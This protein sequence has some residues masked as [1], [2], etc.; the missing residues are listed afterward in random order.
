M[1]TQNP[2]KP[3]LLVCPD[4]SEQNAYREADLTAGSTLEC[5]HCGVEL[6]V[7][8]DRD[9]PDDPQIWRLEL[10]DDSDDVAGARS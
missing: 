3:L 4:C 6:V 8:H 10:P 1:R 5:Q 9:T 2:V 7:T